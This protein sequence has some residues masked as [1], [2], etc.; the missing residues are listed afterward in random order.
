MVLVHHH[1][2]ERLICHGGVKSARQQAKH[3]IMIGSSNVRAALPG[4]LHC[5][6]ASSQQSLRKSKPEEHC[7]CSER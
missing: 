4:G 2:V 7:L 6:E 1:V 5:A 3:S